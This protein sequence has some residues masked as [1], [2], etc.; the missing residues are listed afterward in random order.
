MSHLAPVLLG[1][2]QLQV[3][4]SVRGEKKRAAEPEKNIY[5]LTH[6]EAI[7]DNFIINEFVNR[8]DCVSVLPPHRR[9]SRL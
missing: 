1:N 3:F 9:E 7:V 8:E 5:P 6:S 2:N 4:H